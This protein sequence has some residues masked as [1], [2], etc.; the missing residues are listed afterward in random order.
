MDIHPDEPLQK[1]LYDGEYPE[2]PTLQAP[3][4]EIT[5][6]VT[7]IVQKLNKLPLEQIGNNLKDILEQSQTTLVKMDRLLDAESPTGHELKLVL[8]ELAD[9]ARNI[10]DKADAL[11]DNPK[12]R[13][14]YLG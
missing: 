3:I 9:A 2:L 8:T 11:L 5:K 10:S 12:V 7:Q 13:E 4:E 14:A 6:S 1:V